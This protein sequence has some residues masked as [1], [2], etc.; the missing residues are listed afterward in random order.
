MQR[1]L[2][3]IEVVEV[4]HQCLDAKVHVVVQQPPLQSTA[5]VPFLRLAKFLTHEQQLLARVTP[6]EAVI[7]AQIG[8]T[9]PLVAGHAS[10]DRAFAVDHL[11]M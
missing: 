10:E 6:H 5:K 4:A 1:L 8:E 2:S 7:G 9:P 11:V 3:A